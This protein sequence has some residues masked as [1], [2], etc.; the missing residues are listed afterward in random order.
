MSEKD[1]QTKA[2]YALVLGPIIFAMLSASVLAKAIEWTSSRGLREAAVVVAFAMFLVWFIV[3]T[4]WLLSETR[5]CIISM[6]CITTN[7]I[8]G[9]YIASYVSD[10]MP[11]PPSATEVQLY[12]I[13][14]AAL[15]V[16]NT[17]AAAVDGC[18][19]RFD[20]V[21]IAKRERK[22]KERLD[23]EEKERAEREAQERRA[24]KERKREADIERIL[25]KLRK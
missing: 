6:A 19:A 24:R 10:R 17:F 9:I 12:T 13:V 1:K 3:L 18:H 20:L 5:K 8:V 11:E 4:C 7:G 25:S 14:Y 21:R 23:R 15:F 16:L 2:A 22:E